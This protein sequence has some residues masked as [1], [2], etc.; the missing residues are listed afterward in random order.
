M[1]QQPTPKISCVF[2]TWSLL[3]A[4]EHPVGTY[5]IDAEERQG[6]WDGIPLTVNQEEGEGPS[7]EQQSF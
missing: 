2:G 4:G 5:E 3:K 1:K 7:L 6:C